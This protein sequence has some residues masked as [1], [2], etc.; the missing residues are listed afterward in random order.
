MK[1]AFVTGATGF[2]GV[3]LVKQLHDLGW[4]ISAIH[5]KSIDHPVLN[6]LPIS[7][8]QTSL[9][10][11]EALKKALPNSA[12]TVFHV[13]ADTAQWKPLYERQ[14]KTNVYGTANLIEAVQ[15][16][17]L[18]RFI[19]VSSISAYGLHNEVVQD[20]SPSVAHESR[21]NYSITKWQ[22]EELVKKAITEKSLP[23]VILNPCHIIGPWDT[24]NWVQLFKAVKEDDLP[25]IPPA[26]G[27]F[28]WVEEVAKAL[29]TAT[30]KGAIGEN[31]ILG[32]PHLRMKDLVNEIQRQV[33]KPVS[34]KANSPAFLRAI[35]P[36]FRIGSWFT[37]KEPQLTPDKVLM[38][39]HNL[40]ADDS[41]ARK[42]LGYQ[43]KSPEEI[44]RTTLSW[45]ET[46][47]Q[48]NT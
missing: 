44:V 21:H 3:N 25:G 12:F 13:A 45:L 29:I 14:T 35:E 23:A 9:D 1:Q 5:R 11:V 22:A 24:N 28:A 36:I 46:Y 18:N 39:T 33:D 4:N 20:D 41:K 27:V 6:K 8:H 43:H 7:W 19:H 48:P 42:I 40:Q 38:L 30:E 10:E 37:G 15:G 26:Q 2:L 47:E 32:G 31:Y 34:K 16:K 17:E